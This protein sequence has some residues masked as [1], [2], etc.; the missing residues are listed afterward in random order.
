[1]RLGSEFGTRGPILF[2]LLAFGF[3]WGVWLSSPVLSASTGA[4]SSLLRLV[5]AFGP[6][7]AGTVV[8]WRTGG[9]PALRTLLARTRRWRVAGRWYVLALCLPAGTS[10]AATGIAVALGDP[11]PS[12]DAPPITAA[13]P[14]PLPDTPLGVWV[15][16]PFVAVQTLLIGSPVAEEFGWRGY[17]LPWAL[18]RRGPLTA[19]LLV[20]VVWGVWHAPLLVGWVGPAFDVTLPAFMLGITADAVLFTW[21]YLRTDRSLLLAIV[22]HAAISVT[23]LFLASADGHPYL[24]PLVTWA[25]VAVIGVRSAWT[26]GG[27]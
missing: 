19:S 16:L 6:S 21:L 9:R 4:P 27:R 25:V 13:N 26:F 23:G 2:V 7:L 18:S 24:E 8:L 15:L 1:M 14:V 10:L 20:G 11:V 22:F 5:G 12:F 17:L 3:S